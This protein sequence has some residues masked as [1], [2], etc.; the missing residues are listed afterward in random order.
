MREKRVIAGLG[1]FI[2]LS[3]SVAIAGNAPLLLQ[4]EDRAENVSL[5][6]TLAW[7]AIE[8]AT[9]YEVQVSSTNDF[10]TSDL[11]IV[12]DKLSVVFSPRE[13]AKT[14][15]W[16]VRSL[17][18]DGPSEWST[19]WSF[20]RICWYPW[21]ESTLPIHHDTVALPV[22]LEWTCDPGVDS[23]QV[24]I[25]DD[26]AFNTPEYDTHVLGNE[27]TFIAGNLYSA[28]EVFWRVRWKMGVC[29]PTCCPCYGEWTVVRSFYVQ[30]CCTGITGNVDGDIDENVD[31]GDVTAIISYLFIPPNPEPPCMDE[32]NI[33]GDA[34]GIVD[35]GDLTGLIRYLYIPPNPAP[36]G[37][38]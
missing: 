15:Y 2:V 17:G 38:Q 4:P 32:A 31:I 23:F 9:A 1:V 12:T 29:C 28:T 21:A 30:G 5:P 34:S 18:V 6:T 16:R 35:I 37:C 7:G 14:L 33:D 11:I 20:A 10:A 8:A 25:D 3:A 13:C 22:T 19:V 26:P 24:Q 27:R 36:A